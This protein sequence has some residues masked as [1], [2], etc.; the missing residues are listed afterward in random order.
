MRQPLLSLVLSAA[1][2]SAAACQQARE[3]STY[4]GDIAAAS[5]EAAPATPEAVPAD[6]SAP[7]EA[8]APAANSTAPHPAEQ[9]AQLTD[10]AFMAQAASGGMMEVEAAKQAQKSSDAMVKGLAEMILKDHTKA[11]DELKA[12]AAKKGV[13]LP[14]GPLDEAKTTLDKLMAVSGKEFDRLYLEE[15]NAAHEKAI[16]LFDAQA[17]SGQDAAVRAFAARTLPKLREHAEMFR[18][19]QKMM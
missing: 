4:G 3:G 1:L 9:N 18:K 8:S 14:A 15:M 17:K 10:A 16:A 2:L 6:A 12:L 11:N 13:K 7:P 19:N 5:A